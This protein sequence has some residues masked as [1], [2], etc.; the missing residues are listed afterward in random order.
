MTFRYV[1]L[2]CVFFLMTS[3]TPKSRVEI[4]WE[5]VIQNLYAPKS[6]ADISRSA[7]E[8]YTS[9]DRTGGNND[10]SHGFENL[11]N[12]WLELAD[13]K[14][15]GVMTRLWFT[16]IKR[17]TRFQFIFDDEDESRLEV[18]CDD[19]YEKRDGFPE[20]LVSIDQNCVYLGFPI[21]YE[22]RLRI[23]ISDDGYSRGKG[24][25]YFQINATQLKN[26]TVSSAKFPIPASVVVAAKSVTDA[27][28]QPEVS[29]SG[30]IQKDFLLSGIEQREV[31]TLDSGGM[32]QKL[33]M[34]LD[35]WAAM[36]FQQRREMVRNIWLRIYWDDSEEDSVRVPIGVFFGQM[37]EPKKLQNLYFSVDET[38]F[39]CRFPMPFKKRARIT[40]DHRG[41]ASISG[42]VSLLCDPQPVPSNL[43]YFHCGWMQSSETSKGYPH[44]V[45]NVEGRGRLAGCLLGVASMDRSFWVLESD[46]TILRNRS[47]E[48]YWQGTGLE[49]YFNGGWYYRTVFQNPLFGLTTKRPFRTVQYRFHLPD[50]V[51]FNQ[52][53]KMSFER[54]PD[55]KSRA[56]FDSTVYY[57]LEDPVAAVGNRFRKGC[58]PPPRDE[59]KTRS[60]MTRL[61]DYE[62]FNDFSNALKLTEHAISYWSYPPPMLQMLTL[63][64]LE[65]QAQQEGYSTVREQMNEMGNSKGA[66]GAAA[67]ALIDFHEKNAAL[68]FVYSNKKTS[69]Y[70]D[71]KP[72]LETSDSTRSQVVAIALSSGEHVLAIE[73]EAGTWPDWVQAGLKNK[74]GMMAIDP[75]W[76]CRAD[77][78]GP[79]SELSYRA[80]DWDQMIGLCKG[81]PELEAVP[82]VY[83]DAYPGLQSQVNA[84]RA[85]YMPTGTK[86]VVFRKV[87]EVD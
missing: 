59:F 22:K 2:V 56:V 12:G 53:L 64:A 41:E 9:H 81:P 18:S 37:W 74:K 44:E 36:T 35:G 4:T 23:L 27:L 15:P 40:L 33:R 50:A 62:K 14:G 8:I 72:M 52:A 26:Q 68:L 1:L 32:I 34:E 45:L 78:I 84:V 71:G 3:C 80:T 16:G 63:R 13:L 46:E 29:A 69:V 65:Y 5:Q 87:F 20:S 67:S 85:V 25:L 21:P 48:V 60:L 77:P 83:P 54:G 73:T 7:T 30:R 86:K 66:V 49:D 11:E 75:T 51:T 61:W 28:L 42:R 39:E 70:L 82:F 58:P 19:F 17:E 31:V 10:Y 38:G 76:E 79:W 55:N 57:Y 43:G 6:I 47:K 24:K